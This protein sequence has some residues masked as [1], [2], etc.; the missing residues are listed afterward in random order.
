MPINR[1]SSVHGNSSNQPGSTWRSLSIGERTHSAS[2]DW[3]DIPTDVKSRTSD[4]GWPQPQKDRANEWDNSLANSS[5]SKDGPKWQ[6]GED[7]TID[8]Q[9]PSAIL[10]REHDSRILSQPSPDD[11]V[12]YY[13]DPQGAIQGPFAGSDIIGWFE[14]GYFGIDL[15]VRLANA[16]HD[17]PFSL[18][19]D[20]MPHLRAKAR[21]PPGFTGP[22]QSEINEVPIKPNL[23]SFGKL[24][25]GS[26]EV[27][28]MKNDPRFKHTTTEAENRF[29]ESLMSSNITGGSLEKFSLSEGLQGYFGNNSNPALGPETGDNL[30]ELAKR[31]T[32][33]RQK[34]LPKPYS[35]WPGRDGASIGPKSDVLQDSTIP[36]SNILSAVADNLRQQPHPQNAD[37]MSILQGLSDRSTSGV[38]SGVGGWSNFPV[39]GGLDP[40]QDKLDM[41]HGQNFPTQA[42]FGVQQRLQQH[43]TSS[44]SNLRPQG[45]DTPA[46]PLTP[47]KLLASGL[48][49]DPQLL[50]LLQQQYIS[51]LQ[52]QAPAPPQMSILD[53][54][55][56]LKQQQQKQEQQ[57]QQQQQQLLLQQQLLSQVLSDRH[58]LQRFGE[59]SYGPLPPASLPAGNAS[60]DHLRFQPSH[61]V[62]QMGS[63]NQAP[64]IQD[65][66]ATNLVNISQNLSQDG[67]HNI[68]SE[69]TTIHLPHQLF[70]N[71]VHQKGWGASLP[72]QSE[73]VQKTGSL[74]ES[75]AIITS[76]QPEVVNKFPQEQALPIHL[77]TSE[78]VAFAS[79]EAVVNC[80]PADNLEKHVPF[81]G[82]GVDEVLTPEQ[83]H[84]LKVHPDGVIK[85]PEVQ[86]GQSNNE[87]SDLKEAKSVEPRE[88][89]KSSE[90]KSKKQKSSKAQSSDLARGVSKIQ[91][92][93]QSETEGNSLNDAKSGTRIVQGEILR[94]AYEEEVRESKAGIPTA[95]VVDHQQGKSPL[96]AQV[97]GDVG[98]AFES[99]NEFG[100]A[101]SV[102]QVNTQVYTGQRAWKPAPGFKPKSLLE[103]QQEEQRKAAE[104]TVSDISAS[105]SSMS[106]SS[107]WAG[108][109]ANKQDTDNSELNLVEPEGSLNQKSKKSQLHDLLGD[110]VLAR[111]LEKEIMIP[112]SV[113]SRP[114]APVSS[115]QSD[116]VDN[117]DF[118]E[119]K[120]TKKNRKKSAK[121]KNAG[122]K[123]AVPV[124]S[125]DV[126][127]G[128]SSNE[129]G[130]STRQLQ[131]EKEVSTAVPSGPS[132][133]DFVVWKG[134]NANPSPAPAWSTESAKLARRTSLRDILK[135]QEKKVSSGQQ[136]IP[137]PIPQKSSQP[138]SSRGTGPSWSSSAS[139]PAKAASPIK[140][141]SQAS[142]Q[143]RHKADEDLF[144]GPLDQPKQETK[145]SDFPLLSSQGSWGKNTPGKG[146]LGGSLSRQKST[147]GRPAERSLSS[148]PALKGKRDVLTKHSE[149]MDFR[150]WCESECVRLIGTK[151]T[152][153][154]EFC[155]KQSRS[156]AEILLTENLGSFDPDHEFIEKFLNYKDFLPVDVL[157]I[158]F[159]SRND[160]K[161]AGF[162]PG[163]VNSVNDGTKDYSEQG[164][165][166]MVSDGSTK[167]AGKKKGKKGKKVSPAVLGFNVVSNRIMMG[168]IQTVE[169]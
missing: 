145:K 79:S 146:N 148:S 17:S 10:D 15:L 27:D 160:R 46:G 29:L 78:P 1:E 165:H 4:V 111:S 129:K 83:V 103:I 101:A 47:E 119:A 109:V 163:D 132:L 100:Q 14:A 34:S 56:L 94:E 143:S 76:Q 85:E 36:P 32:L 137:V 70:G 30:Y 72:E 58:S 84:Y 168:E 86:G 55:L 164:S 73:D 65:E 106:F 105:L 50:S 80:V 90:K 48:S 87:S 66:R 60:M 142:S 43:N 89:K 108:V 31:M 21:P 156:E 68:S 152:S 114:P 110:E 13:K 158:A 130:K 120:E 22:K 141:N 138:Q 151:D 124:A 123:V 107:P 82:T 102:S 11:L 54:Y 139:S 127:V 116:S 6:I 122:T 41:L 169:D 57:Q 131:Q 3:R 121:A 69:T 37:F 26:S 19:G 24:H 8:R 28:M 115:T 133:G 154:L 161:V 166:S 74:L 113:S 117:D 52:P 155:M 149:A 9:Q 42:A 136:Q 25:A 93:K 91:Q 7:L 118:I 104:M 128:S 159:Q 153:F 2:H 77:R 147:G 63:Q 40:R 135:E 95:E 144:W 45:F 5:Y 150:D 99:K 88:V 125:A 97:S 96:P 61:E 112:D 53:E 71:T 167:S 140:I 51:Q 39:Q 49:Q 64:H 62:F 35:F 98:Q 23:S 33:E 157:D 92:P 18:L 81:V 67:S 38:N 12:L 126:A 16:P 134:E 162:G 59:Q 75:A 20:V 44:L